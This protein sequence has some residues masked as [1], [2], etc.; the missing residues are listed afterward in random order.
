MHF[1]VPLFAL[2]GFSIA[3]AI[4]SQEQGAATLVRRSGPTCTT[5]KVPIK[6]SA[7]NV[8]INLPPNYDANSNPLGQ[9]TNSLEA[10][11]ETILGNVL[12][13][14]ILTEGTYNI[15]MQY[16]V[17]EVKN[18][19]RAQTLQCEYLTDVNGNWC[20]TSAYTLNTFL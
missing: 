17:P 20:I 15:N 7:S 12:G 9:L 18:A 16:C 4:P 10:S 8:I 1:T 13:D 6:A 14:L 5:F 3:A 11:G 19:S 2:I